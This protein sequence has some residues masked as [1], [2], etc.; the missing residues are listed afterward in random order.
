[1]RSACHS[2]RML[3]FLYAVFFLLFALPSRSGAQPT[4][5]LQAVQLLNLADSLEQAG[6][7]SVAIQTGLQALAFAKRAFP[8]DTL[9]LF[10]MYYLLGTCHLTVGAY[11]TSEVYLRRSLPGMR[12]K[13]GE[14]HLM[15][16]AC[17]TDIGLANMYQAA[18]DQAITYFDRS[19]ETYLNMDP[20]DTSRIII[21]LVNK[22]ACGIYKQDVDQ[23]IA[24][25]EEARQ[26]VNQQSNPE[27]RHFG[28]VNQGLGIC[29][30]YEDPQRAMTYF[31]EANDRYEEAEEFDQVNYANNL[32]QIGLCYEV[33]GQFQKASDYYQRTLNRHRQNLGPRHPE[34]AR[35]YEDL[36]NLHLTA[37]DPSAA[38]P[39]LEQA[40]Q[41]RTEVFGMDHPELIGPHIALGNAYRL[42]GQY[43]LA[44]EQ[45]E[46]A[47]EV[48]F[49]Q[50]YKDR[51]YIVALIG[52]AACY[53]EQEQYQKSR[54]ILLH[55]QR[56]A[57]NYG[58]IEA[59]VGS[60]HHNLSMSYVGLQEYDQA[61]RAEQKAIRSFRRYFGPGH[62]KE[63]KAQVQLAAIHAQRG[64]LSQSLTYLNQAMGTLGYSEANPI[65]D[66]PGPF[67]PAQLYML[68][69]YGQVYGQR[70]Q[71]TKSTE[72][73]DQAIRYFRQAIQLLDYIKV[74]FQA[75]DSK[76]RISAQNRDLIEEYLHLL[77][78]RYQEDA[79]VRWLEQGFLLSEKAK[80]YLLL[81]SVRKAQAKTMAGLPDAIL[82]AEQSLSASIHFYQR[83]WYEEDRAEESE[84][85]Q[86]YKDSL[87]RLQEDYR[88]LMERIEEQYPDYYQLKF[89]VDP[90]DLA[91]IRKDLLGPDE[92]LFAYF[93]GEDHLYSFLLTR[94]DLTA[95]QTPVDQ[96]LKS[97]VRDLRTS[98]LA[99]PLAI[100]RTEVLYL[101]S[102]R[103]FAEAS[104]ELYRQLIAP[105]W[106]IRRATGQ[107]TIIPDGILG[108]VPFEV[109]LTQLPSQ[110]E[111]FKDHAYLIREVPIH[112]SYS[113]TLWWEMRRGGKQR[114][115]KKVLAVAPE[116]RELNE[117][118]VALRETSLSPLVYNTKEAEGVVERVGGTLLRGDAARKSNF[119]EQAE[120]FSILH[121]AT[122]GKA[123]DQAGEYSFLAFSADSATAGPGILYA[124]DLYANRMPADMVVLSACET[125]LGELSQGEGL[126]SLARAFSYAGAKSVVMTLWQV[127]DARSANLVQSFYQHLQSGATK[128][129][130]LRQA[131]LDY[132]DQHSHTDAHPYFWASYA[133]IGDVSPITTHSF[134]TGPYFLVALT[135]L[136]V[137]CLYWF[138]RKR[139]KK[140]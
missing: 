49:N 95:Q 72:D 46:R 110:P 127:D 93:V 138:L 140:M 86:I 108:Y 134:W 87:F 27:L 35:A 130:S 25:Y 106:E 16:A 115:T 70:Y 76:E 59:V 125:G 65:P 38:I 51:D 75:D 61:I 12:Q 9:K 58:T 124:Q 104:H 2:R 94:N 24:F 37:S 29:Y 55:A 31:Q 64:N 63:G 28:M 52:Q 15:V 128:S 11:A 122:H 81:E 105:L 60:I 21:G 22:A 3:A 135:L 102:S 5:S 10:P 99:Y 129:V 32:H 30:Q 84:S 20:V 56:E 41:I 114:Y 118:P 8:A 119:L 98:L 97:L 120:A 79:D 77:F 68:Q 54:S 47:E 7:Y 136:L 66:G 1:M 131:K 100:D 116:F 13:L 50:S 44:L 101:E 33:L 113:A 117:G 126:I 4:D 43:R 67:L 121:L 23:A 80:G 62:F 111:R 92:S 123:N 109:L 19:Q 74:H 18:Y 112:Y 88:E 96:S 71:E 40:L 83:K 45:F 91:A 26:L 85:A 137:I 133:L 82:E 36:G 17:Y 57:Q 103:D 42:L 69:T 73:F 90:I 39:F 53:S 6:E 107:L 14:D 89:R 132:L 34:T 139:N 78:T 48:A